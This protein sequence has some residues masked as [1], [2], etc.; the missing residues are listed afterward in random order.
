MTFPTTAQGTLSPGQPITIVNTSTQ[1]SL[2][3]SG[4]SFTGQSPPAQTDHP[5]DF[6]VESSTC[7]VPI[8]P[9]GSCQVVVAFAPQG[10]GARTAI[11]Q[12]ASDDSSSELSVALSGTGGPLPQGPGGATGPEGATG[13]RGPR[14]PVA[15]PER[16]S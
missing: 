12:I 13:P 2:A 10:Q 4:F 15:T 11:L 7:Y 1:S 6:L 3:F 9:G 5:E 8:E 16:S 14:S